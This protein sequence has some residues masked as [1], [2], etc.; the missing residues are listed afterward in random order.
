MH[1]LSEDG[2]FALGQQHGGSGFDGVGA[3]EFGAGEEFTHFGSGRAPGHRTERVQVVGGQHQQVGTGAVL[4][5]QGASL[6]Q[7]SL[8][9]AFS[10]RCGSRCR[11]EQVEGAAGA[12]GVTGKV[13]Q[14]TCPGQGAGGTGR[15]HVQLEDSGRLDRRVLVAE[16]ENGTGSRHLARVQPAE[17]ECRCLVR[18]SQRARGS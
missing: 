2:E 6:G 4:G 14:G 5:V 10:P 7:M 16:A 17:R 12:D 3:Q 1:E 8:C 13:E 11:H 9:G 18:P 15:Q